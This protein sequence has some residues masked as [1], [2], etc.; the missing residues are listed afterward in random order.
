M[1][2]EYTKTNLTMTMESMEPTEP[3]NPLIIFKT[4]HSPKFS[5]GI[6]VLEPTC[7]EF[8]KTMEQEHAGYKVM[9]ID[10]NVIPVWYGLFNQNLKI[11]Y[12]TR[13]G[14][15]KTT[16]DIPPKQIQIS[17]D[18]FKYKIAAQQWDNDCCI[19]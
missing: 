3:T 10:T 4:V 7:V 6:D 13:V 5:C 12:Q 11:D 9:A 8:I 16:Q 15:V 1:Y 14:L 18:N 17:Y 2:I 19:S